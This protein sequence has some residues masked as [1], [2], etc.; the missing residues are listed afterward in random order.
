RYQ[1]NGNLGYNYL[2]WAGTPL[3]ATATAGLRYT[4]NPVVPYVVLGTSLRGTFGDY[5]NGDTQASLTGTVALSGQFG[6]FSRPFFDYTAFQIA[7]SQTVLNGQSPFLFDR[8]AD[9]QVLTLGFTQQVYGPFR[10]GIQTALSLDQSR[11]IDTVYTLE[12]S[13]RTYAIAL[14]FS[15]IRNAGSLTLRISDFNWFG[16]PGRFSGI[17][18]PAVFN[19]VTSP[20]N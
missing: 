3:P 6:H 9:Q 16:E 10:F 7:Y 19:G 17:N 11:T 13:R 5:S 2:I 14:N 18:A 15:P 20:A 4:P 12:Y 1:I 8:V